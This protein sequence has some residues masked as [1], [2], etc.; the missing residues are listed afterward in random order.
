MIMRLEILITMAKMNGKR[1]ALSE[2]IRN[3]FKE[4]RLLMGVEV[5]KVNLKT[6]VKMDSPI[7]ICM[8]IGRE[9]KY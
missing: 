7:T 3:M 1:K 9:Y 4:V 2:I 8:S 5:K 6:W